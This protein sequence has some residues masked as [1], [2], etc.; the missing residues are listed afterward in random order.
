[1][2]RGPGVEVRASSIRV[3]FTWE[4]RLERHTLR[5][6]GRPLKPT[7]AN[8]QYAH[9]LAREIRARIESG[10][11][12]LADYFPASGAVAANTVGDQL[13][14]WLA[15]QRIEATTRAG[16]ASAVKFWRAAIGSRGLRALRTS[17]ILTAIADRPD[18]SGKTVN[19]YTSVLRAALDL[20]VLDGKLA[21]NPAAA[22]EPAAH[23]RPVPDPFDADERERIIE[24]IAG[25]YPGHVA[26]LIEFWFWTGLRTSEILGL[27]WDNVDLTKGEIL[28][29]Q[30]RIRGE[31]KQRTKTSTVRLVRLNSRAR[32][33]LQRQRGLTQ[34]T[35][36]AVFNNPIGG[37]PWANE[38]T[39]Q[40][41]YWAPTL[42]RLGIRYRRPYNMRHTYATAML[43]AG[44]TPAFCAKQL[45]HS[46]EMFLRT[47]AR[48]IDGAASDRE[49]R[50]LEAT[51]RPEL[52]TDGGIAGNGNLPGTSPRDMPDSAS[53]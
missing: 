37:G 33:A 28:V 13:D 15:A 21:A 3:S 43:M 11:F 16:Y 47:Y 7:R 1:M 8:V 35:G 31:L 5:L 18:L 53:S 34:V 46:V 48:W 4:G 45:G 41:T 52:S 6:D 39:V 50:R 36:A 51:L 19:N 9:R 27:P 20:A 30:S 24:A 2:G 10:D 49:M 22:I 17:D 14:N 40:R 12:R 42:K 44:M 38:Y 26:N 25:R 32:A 29:N 23:Q